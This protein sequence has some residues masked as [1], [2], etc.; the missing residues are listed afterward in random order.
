MASRKRTRLVPASGRALVEEM[1]GRLLRSPQAASLRACLAFDEACGQQVRRHARAEKLV[2][3]VLHVRVDAGVWMTELSFLRPQILERLQQL[4]GAAVVKDIRLRV[5]VAAGEA[6]ARDVSV[7]AR[8]DGIADAGL[9]DT[10]RRLLRL[11]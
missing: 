8:L 2:A 10:V 6:S 9:R 4:L 1:L 7:D 5:A 11:T 3:G